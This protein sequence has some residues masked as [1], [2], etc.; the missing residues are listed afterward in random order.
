MDRVLK[1]VRCR[2]SMQRR[3]G[4]IRLDDQIGCLAEQV[5]AA[6]IAQERVDDQVEVLHQFQVEVCFAAAARFGEAR[7]GQGIEGLEGA[8]EAGELDR[9]EEHTSELQSRQYLVC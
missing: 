5:P 4:A 8:E 1:A 2:G 3:G 7:A 6:A 9:S